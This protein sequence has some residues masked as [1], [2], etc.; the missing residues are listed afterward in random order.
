[1]IVPGSVCWVD[2]ST[3]DPRGSRAL[4]AELFGWTYQVD[5]GRSRGRYARALCGGRPVAGVAGTAAPAGHPAT[6]TLYLASSDI[7][8]TAEMI[9]R[10]GGQILY[11]PAEVAGHGG[12]LIGADPTGAAIGF[13]HPGTP[14]VFH[15]AEP[16]S[17]WW[18]ELNTWNGAVADTF[19][20]NLF[21]YRIQQVGD[22][23]DADHTIWSHYGYPIL[24]RLQMNAEW[25][26]AGTAPHWVLHFA[27]HPH[28]G[29]DAAVDRVLDL[30]GQLDIDPYDTELGR[31]AH[32][33]DPSGASFALIDP[34]KR[35][36]VGSDFV[37]GSARVDD[38][39]DD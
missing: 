9:K 36:E 34:T 14:W 10:L 19:F 18:A 20:T 8:H 24:G 2:V 5:Q 26:D 4:Y 11:G 12:V 32:V 28:T 38:P 15:T 27:V 22:G 16:G 6:W 39:Y 3:T 23:I 1:V 35:I 13:F 21:G 17:L 33:R 7:R 37:P 29:I 31:I 30:G 25:A